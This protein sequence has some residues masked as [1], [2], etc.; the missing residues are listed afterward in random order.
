MSSMFK[1]IKVRALTPLFGQAQRRIVPTAAEIRLHL[2]KEEDK[3][4]TGAGTVAWIASG[5]NIRT[6]QYVSACRKPTCS[7][8]H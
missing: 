5:L 4:G 1:R 2:T 6:V 8:H 7:G 3:S